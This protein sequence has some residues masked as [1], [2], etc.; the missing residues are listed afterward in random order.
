LATEA[1]LDPALSVA[2]DVK[3]L[4]SSPLGS[5]RLSVSGHVY[6]VMGGIV[7]TVATPVGVPG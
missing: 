4:L 7:T 5:T 6:D 3:T 2:A 1:V